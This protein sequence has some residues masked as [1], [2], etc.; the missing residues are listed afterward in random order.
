MDDVNDQT[1]PGS[2]DAADPADGGERRSGDP[3]STRDGGD[4]SHPTGAAEARE[5]RENDPPA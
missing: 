3:T 1:E 4:A 5:N 2:A